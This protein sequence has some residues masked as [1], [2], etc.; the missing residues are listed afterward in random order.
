MKR[1]FLALVT[2]AAYLST[3]F[4]AVGCQPKEP[5]PSVGPQANRPAPVTIVAGAEPSEQQRADLLAAKDALFQ[6]LSGK[7][8]AAMAEGP[9]QAIGVCQKEAPELAL[10]VQEE[11][12]VQ[13]GRV[14]VRLRNPNNTGPDWAAPLI[15]ARTETPVFVNLSNGHAAALLPIKLQSQC[16]M[17]HGPKEQIAPVIQSQL[18]KLYPN[19][20]ATGFQ[21]GE[22]R[23]WF[24]V[25]KP[26]S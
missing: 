18:T 4:L 23:G 2:S 20:E 9:A 3:A 1:N 16:L 11:L 7:L 8:M 5:G 10:A 19:D 17:C 14:G 13:I 25:E 26:A 12:G 6:R 22:L 21:E 15:A 24:W